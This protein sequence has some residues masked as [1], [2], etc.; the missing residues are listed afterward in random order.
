MLEERSAK[1]KGLRK[2]LFWLYAAATLA[3]ILAATLFCVAFISASDAKPKAPS[4]NDDKTPIVDN[5]QNNNHQKPN[6]TPPDNNQNPPSQGGDQTDPPIG[7][8]DTPV[9]PEGSVVWITAP[10]LGSGN[11]VLVN[12]DHTYLS[13]NAG[14]YTGNLTTDN[15]TVVN[16]KEN[17]TTTTANLQVSANQVELSYAFVDMLCKMAD[18]MVEGCD[19]TTC[20]LIVHS[21]FMRDT[22]PSSDELF[23]GLSAVLRLNNEGTFYQFKDEQRLPRTIRE[24]VLANCHDFGIIQRYPADKV[25]Q[26]GVSASVAQYRYVG[27]IH[28]KYMKAQNYCLEEYLTAVKAYNFNKRLDITVDDEAYSLY[29]VKEADANT[30]GIPVPKDAK[31]EISGNNVDGYVVLI[32]K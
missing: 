5:N 16:V 8:D 10:G 19:N 22:D 25:A 11:L 15:L 12:K 1:V 24:W 23:T 7:G 17:R 29:F 6:N 2:K 28:A 3:T 13:A 30:K 18:A 4:T 20:N 26:T 31:Y 14:N 32:K 27:K 9:I 21:G